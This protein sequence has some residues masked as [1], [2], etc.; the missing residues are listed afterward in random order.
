MLG[1]LP[2]TK[3]DEGDAVPRYKFKWANLPP[4][5]LRALCRD[6]ALDGSG[7]PA[8][9]L[10]TAYGARPSEEFIRETWDTLRESW[11]RTDKASREWVV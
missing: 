8:V 7:E 11:L 5:L 2:G 4:P 6:L 1:R 9:T 3:S 10:Q